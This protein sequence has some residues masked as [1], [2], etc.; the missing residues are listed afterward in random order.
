MQMIMHAGWSEDDGG[1]LA[2]DPQFMTSLFNL[3]ILEKEGNPWHNLYTSI[4]KKGAKLVCPN[5]QEETLDKLAD[6]DESNSFHTLVITNSMIKGGSA[7]TLTLQK[8]WD[9]QAK[10]EDECCEFQ[11][12]REMCDKNLVR[13]IETKLHSYSAGLILY[14]DKR[15]M[16]KPSYTV[17]EELVIENGLPM[18]VH[19][20]TTT[21]SLVGGIEEIPK[22][23]D[24]DDSFEEFLFQQTGL[25]AQ[26]ELMDMEPEQSS[27]AFN[28][29][30]FHFKENGKYYKIFDSDKI[31]VSSQENLMRCQLLFFKTKK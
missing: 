20:T 22:K 24:D 9:M 11:C 31:G 30:V 5:C 18:L 25:G 4:V 29:L 23:K 21:F 16:R 19:G 13:I 3:S 17:D 12:K 28:Q 6:Y 1:E 7:K 26:L 27:A 14:I 15:T 10:Y 2:V 8:L